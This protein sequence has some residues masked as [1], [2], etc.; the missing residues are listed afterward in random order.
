[1]EVLS[2]VEE[3]ANSTCF[4]SLD[5]L[6]SM[7]NCTIPVSIT[8]IWFETG[9]QNG[10]GRAEE[11]SGSRTCLSIHRLWTKRPLQLCSDAIASKKF[12]RTSACPTSWRLLTFHN[13]T[14]G[15]ANPQ[16]YWGHSWRGKLTPSNFK[17]HVMI[18]CTANCKIVYFS[19]LKS[20]QIF[21]IPVPITLGQQILKGIEAIHDVV[22]L[23]HQ[24]SNYLSCS[25]MYCK[26]Q[27]SL[28]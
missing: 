25:I 22:S 7:I 19:D 18:L 4:H 10:S 17:L 3:T 20:P 5:F 27:N 11:T 16:G 14:L 23:L 21:V 24:I 9:A 8:L 12:S 15:P 26:L 1:M 13:A 6:I 2:H 28:F